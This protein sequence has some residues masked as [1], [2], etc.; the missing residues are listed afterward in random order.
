MVRKSNKTGIAKEVVLLNNIQGIRL[1]PIIELRNNRLTGWE[2]L[3][4]LSIPAFTEFFFQHL[5]TDMTLSLFMRQAELVS[6]QYPQETL[7]INLPVRVLLNEERLRDIVRQAVA[8]RHNVAIEI[9]DPSTLCGMS[10]TERHRLVRALMTLRKVGWRLWMDDVTPALIPEVGSLGLFFDG[11]KT[12]WREMRRRHSE[13]AALRKLVQQAKLLGERV[14][15]EG[16]ENHDDL[17]HA[18]ASGAELGQG[19]LWD[20]Q[21]MQVSHECLCA[22]GYN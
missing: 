8:F 16:I 1:Q 5:S 2:V 14:L 9:Q 6:Q 21:I 20:E 3:S 22:G 7:F 18:R 10:G 4:Q 12:D 11:V 17:N 19:Y 15:I 13:P